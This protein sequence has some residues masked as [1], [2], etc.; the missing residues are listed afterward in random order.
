MP[1]E[2]PCGSGT[3]KPLFQKSESLTL[4]LLLL[5]A[6]SIAL[7]VLD[8]HRH[9]LN[10][11][12]SALSV[13][14]YPVQAA[15][16]TPFQ[17]AHWVDAELSSRQRLLRA[18]RELRAQ[19]LALQSRLQRMQSLEAEN[20]HLRALLG[21]ARQLP[22][23]VEVA[24]IM[25]VDLDPYRHQ[26]TLNR[27][28]RQGVHTGEA[29]IDSHG[30][31]GQIVHAGPLTSQALLITDPSHSI[32]VEDVRNGLRSIARGDGDTNTL[33]LPYIPNNADLKPGDL[34]VSSGLG[35]RFPRGYPVARVSR[36]VRNPHRRFA[37]VTAVPLAHLDRSREVLVI[38]RKPAAHRV[39][40]GSGKKTGKTGAGSTGGKS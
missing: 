6:L 24:Q 10:Q 14:V 22:A 40:P 39:S 25:R 19:S 28:T 1:G 34:L 8:H 33:S 2:Q 32:P 9:Q 36:V 16:N 7:I 21:S 18:N 38:T 26:V 30:I 31:M 23:Q 37:K 3:I 29:L 13:A 17:V 5:V 20:T 12:R 15:V 4:R 11:L 27:G 35:G